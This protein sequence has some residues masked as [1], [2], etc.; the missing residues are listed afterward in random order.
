MT[1]SVCPPTNQTPDSG[2]SAWLKKEKK[3]LAHKTHFVEKIII[4]LLLLLWCCGLTVPVGGWWSPAGHA[5]SGRWMIQ[6]KALPQLWLHPE[7]ASALNE[8]PTTAETQPPAQELRFTFCKRFYLTK[9]ERTIWL[10]Y[11][12]AICCRSSI[13]NRE[14]TLRVQ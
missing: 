12:R 7:S 6:T 8:N 2:I 1:S 14:G 3:E 4:N 11:L 10:F 5:S 9:T 13:Q